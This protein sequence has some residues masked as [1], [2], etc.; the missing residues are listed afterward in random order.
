MLA[1]VRHDACLVLLPQVIG[2]HVS[3]GSND[4]LEWCSVRKYKRIVFFEI[5]G[6]AR[7]LGAW[8]GLGRCNDVYTIIYWYVG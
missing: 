4:G 7:C 1:D 2:L 5:Y 6:T 8:H 3:G